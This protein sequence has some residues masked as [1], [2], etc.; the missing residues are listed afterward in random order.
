M[1]NTISMHCVS[2]TF[3]YTMPPRS[4]SIYLY[5]R[6]D[7]NDENSARK[8]TK[9]A[10]SSPLNS[11]KRRSTTRASTLAHASLESRASEHDE[12]EWINDDANIATSQKKKTKRSPAAK[13]K[14]HKCSQVKCNKKESATSQFSAVCVHC[15]ARYCSPKCWKTHKNYHKK[16]K[17]QTSPPKSSS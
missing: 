16:N 11:G 15:G 10:T 12:N 6:S 13:L 7:L 17:P 9:A 1:P 14:L 8:P 4:S 2:L 5:L 3:Y